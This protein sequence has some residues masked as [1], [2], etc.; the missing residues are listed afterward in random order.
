MAEERAGAI[1][2][3]WAF[4]LGAL[5][6]GL[7]MLAGLLTW[8][9]GLPEKGG[10]VAGRL[11]VEQSTP[12]SVPAETAEDD[13][14]ALR[15]ELAAAQARIEELETERDRL[16][17]QA[18]TE[19]ILE[20]LAKRVDRIS[21]ENARERAEAVVGISQRRVA[22]A[23]GQWFGGLADNFSMMAAL[24]LLG[25]TGVERLMDIVLNES[26]PMKQRAAA[27]EALAFFPHVRA[28][29]LM[30]HPPQSIGEFLT[31]VPDL[32]EY[33]ARSASWIP[34]ADLSP[35]MS[36]LYEAGAPGAAA[37]DEGALQLVGV[38][39]FV[40]DHEP[41]QRIFDDR[42]LR[43]D[44]GAALLE[45]A[46]WVGGDKAREFVEELSRRHSE[47]AVRDQALAML[48]DW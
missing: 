4:A 46:Q 9:E 19:A 7:I 44:H 23:E 11:A 20:V 25:D 1:G 48:A 26:R 30:L 34:T 17:D 15:H 18:M 42:T 10:A 39:G 8:M 40:H 6:G 47:R 45:A 38:L 35:L 32:N 5:C 43:R 41:A 12:Q 2:L 13:Q 36:D 33:L 24:G 28:V 16:A 31:D 14:D 3:S 27:F 21:G 22:L 29:E 37:G